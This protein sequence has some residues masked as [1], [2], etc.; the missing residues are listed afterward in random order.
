MADYGRALEINSRLHKAYNNRG[1]LRHSI[2]DLD[3]AIADFDRAFQFARNE[4]VGN[5]QANVSLTSGALDGFYAN[6]VI[7]RNNRGNARPAQRDLSGAIADYTEAI[8]LDPRLASAYAN[9]ALA[10][11]NQGEAELAI[12]DCNRAIELDSRRAETYN[13]RGMA[14]KVRG[15]LSGTIE[16]Y[17]RALVL[18]PGLAVAYMNRGFARLDQNNATEAEQDFARALA[19]RPD[20]E[21]RISETKTRTR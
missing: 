10:R 2:G 5:D 4:A 8:T 17:D 13:T 19:L 1:L 16:D 3:G 6:R 14:R 9:R 11:H 15:D 20:L 12:A 18:D 7:A 21:R